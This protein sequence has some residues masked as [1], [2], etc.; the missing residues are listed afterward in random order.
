MKKLLALVVSTC[1]LVAAPAA[2][3]IELSPLGRTTA[4][5]EAQAEI[6]AYHPKSERVFA[7]NAE[8]NRLDIYDF[9]NPAAPGGPVKSVDLSPYGAGPNSV[10]VTDK[11]LVAVAVE[12]EPITDPGQVVFFDVEGNFRAALPAGALPDMLT[13]ADKDRYVLVAN[14]GEADVTGTP[15][16]EGSVTVIK[17]DSKRLSRSSVRTARLGG[18]PRFGEY[19][20]A[21]PGVPFPQ[22]AEP[23]YI[24]E[25]SHGTALVTLQETNA[26]GLLDFERARFLYVRG[27]G[28]KDHGLA[29]NA[30][31]PSDRDGAIAINPWANVAGM[32]QPDAISAYSDRGLTWYVTANEGDARERDDCDEETDVS[33]LT[34]DPTVFPNAEELQENE[35]LGRL[36]VTENLGDSDGDGDYDRLL[37][38]GARS[39]S[40]LSPLGGIVN[41]TGSELERIAAA[42]EPARFNFSNEDPGVF[43]DRSDAK[44]P[45]PEGVD[46][47]EVRGRTYAFLASERQGGLYAYELRGPSATFRDYLNT[48][49]A[50]P[51]AEGDLGPE[52]VLFVPKRDSPTRRAMLL[53][54]N[55][56][57][58]TIAAIDVAP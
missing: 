36:N 21:C 9:S 38:F 27:L 58:G 7:T 32:Y 8:A 2:E 24:A 39:M 16:P 52:G 48:R 34:L 43:D 13:F 42:E 37:A 28:Y 25:G 46:V 35:N 47:G 4:L 57:S 17:L 40:I 53:V 20:I 56:I 45:E 29:R 12:A 11:G 33:D 49:P 15:D 30:L 18:V 51:G 31:D 50:Q 6:A 14:E 1:A 23:E 5:G 44:G 3:A 55:E 19:R 41:D 22:D 10:D 54:T 26:V